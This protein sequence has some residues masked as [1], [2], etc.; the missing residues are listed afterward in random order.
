MSRRQLI[1]LT[2]QLRKEKYDDAEIL[3]WLL[4]FDTL[5]KPVA[6]RAA[7]KWMCDAVIILPEDEYKVLQAVKVAKINHVDPLAYPNPMAVINA[8]PEVR[9]PLLPVDP[10]TVSTFHFLYHNPQEDI[11]IY[12]V[13]DSFESQKNMRD[14]IN[15]HL[16]TRSNPWCLLAANEKGELTWES[17]VYWRKY[18][19]LK[20]RVAFKHGR[21][22]AFSAGTC[23]PRVWY[24]RMDQPYRAEIIEDR[25][26]DNDPLGRRAQ[27]RVDL[28]TGYK[29]F[30]GNIHR[31]NKINGLCEKFHFL[32]SKKPYSRE[33]YWN[34]KLVSKAFSWMTESQLNELLNNSDLEKGILRIPSTVKEIPNQAFQFSAS[35]KEIHVPDSVERIGK[36]VFEGCRNLR[37]VRLPSGLSIIPNN[38]FKDCHALTE[39]T[40]P[41]SVKEIRAYAFAHCSSLVSIRFPR[42]L[43]VIGTGAFVGCLSISKVRIPSSTTVIGRGAFSNMKVNETLIPDTIQAIS[44]DAFSMCLN[45]RK[46]YAGNRWYG[47]FRERYGNKVQRLSTYTDNNKQSA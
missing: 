3:E 28:F 1:L 14:I 40:I 4:Y 7:C 21:L 45:L 17:V 42:G 30:M 43:K 25:A 37:V 5:E 39:I 10:S 6:Q 27:F 15:S 38:L 2:N 9:L 16:G 19:G 13:D 22:Y 31:G 41:Q 12:N 47:I 44:V 24:D 46:I 36:S 33:F 29:E 34:S 11:D 20:K 35:L 8:F 26:I 18:H 32:R 23:H